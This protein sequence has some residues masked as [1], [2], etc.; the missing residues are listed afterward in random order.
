MN[1]ITLLLSSMA[2]NVEDAG[3]VRVNGSLNYAVL[4]ITFAPKITI[5]V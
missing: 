2:E 1:P 4:T 3:I 5:K